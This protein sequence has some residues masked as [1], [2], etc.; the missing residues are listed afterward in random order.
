MDFI[1]LNVHISL[2]HATHV[3]ED[4]DLRSWAG[5]ENIKNWLKLE[6]KTLLDPSH[7]VSLSHSSAVVAVGELEYV[8]PG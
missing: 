5:D 4:G 6:K 2:V 8:A 7:G 3:L 1:N